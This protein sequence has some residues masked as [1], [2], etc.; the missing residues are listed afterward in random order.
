[1]TFQ[2]MMDDDI[3]K[4]VTTVGRPHPHVEVRRKYGR[5]GGRVFRLSSLGVEFD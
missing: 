4:R 5:P 3:E 1:V 2:S